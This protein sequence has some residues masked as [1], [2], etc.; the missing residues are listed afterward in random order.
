ML[1]TT[2]LLEQEWSFCFA[3]FFIFIAILLISHV[4]MCQYHEKMRLYL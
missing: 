1:D 3:T 4:E 2:L